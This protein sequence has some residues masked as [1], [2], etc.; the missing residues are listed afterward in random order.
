MISRC[1]YKTQTKTISEAKNIRHENSPMI[2]QKKELKN[3]CD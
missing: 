3:N 2:S 1:K